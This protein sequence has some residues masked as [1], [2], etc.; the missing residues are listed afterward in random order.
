MAKF[1]ARVLPDVLSADDKILAESALIL[2][3]TNQVP[4]GDIYQYFGFS[5]EVVCRWYVTK[6]LSPDRSAPFNWTEIGLVDGI[7]HWKAHQHCY[8]KNVLMCG[9]CP[10][11]QRDRQRTDTGGRVML[12]FGTCFQTGERRERCDKC[13]Y[14]LECYTDAGEPI[15]DPAKPYDPADYP[16]MSVPENESE[17]PTEDDQ[18]REEPASGS[19][20]SA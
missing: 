15:Y 5:S 11:F 19:Q 18:H 8:T 9:D 14:Y 20:V 13:K 12:R 2:L 16:G 4:P 6:L 17:E 7:R 3:R 1:T 10:F